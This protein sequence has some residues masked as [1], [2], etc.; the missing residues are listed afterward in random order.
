MRDITMTDQQ[1][2]SL[3]AVICQSMKN[4][5]NQI[6]DKTAQKQKQKK[7]KKDKVSMAVTEQIKSQNPVLHKQIINSSKNQLEIHLL[8]N[9]SINYKNQQCNKNR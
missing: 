4:K 1:L 7:E 3:S 5:W 9:D 6:K 2:P 8:T